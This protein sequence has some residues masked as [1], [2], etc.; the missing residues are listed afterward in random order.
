MMLR[1]Y[2]LGIFFEYWFYRCFRNFFMLWKTLM[3]K[4]WKLF[5]HFCSFK[6]VRGK[7]KILA[8]PRR[9]AACAAG[10][11]TAPLPIKFTRGL[12]G[13]QNIW[14]LVYVV[15]FDTLSFVDTRFKKQYA[16][17]MVSILRF[18]VPSFF[19]F[20]YHLC[21]RFQRWCVRP[22]PFRC[23]LEKNWS[24]NVFLVQV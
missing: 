5:W 23:I 12:K 19:P 10:P 6:A 21:M 7:L 3:K 15:T 18:C 20:F 4:H 14:N 13:F 17:S 22:G 9:G 11:R 8:L 1:M 2:I 16:F 24:K